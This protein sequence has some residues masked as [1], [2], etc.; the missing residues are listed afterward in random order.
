MTPTQDDCKLLTGMIEEC[1][2]RQIP[3]YATYVGDVQCSCQQ[4]LNPFEWL[5]H[6]E[7]YNRTF[8]TGN[9]M[10]AVKEAIVKMGKWDIFLNYVTD[11][12]PRECTGPAFERGPFISWLMHPPRFCKLAA[13]WWRKEKV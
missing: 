8:L 9:D 5:H 13:E 10:I 11:V 7:D 1:W 3:G 12:W 4:V 6:R 2:H